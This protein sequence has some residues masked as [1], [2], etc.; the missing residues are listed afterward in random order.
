MSLPPGTW[1]IDPSRSRAE[2]EVKHLGFANARGSFTE[3][4]GTLD[5]DAG[6]AAAAQ[7]AVTVGSVSTGDPGR[8]EFLASERFFDAGRF[9]DISLSTTGT[10]QE[11]DAP[12]VLAGHLTIRDV[13]RP[14][15]LETVISAGP[16]GR[17]DAL[18]IDARCRIS[19]RDYGVK[20]TQALGASN[21]LVADLIDVRL[22]LVAEP[23]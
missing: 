16:G 15:E 10:P 18:A 5:V 19:R 20:F 14:V 4:R 11:I 23:A 9:A 21:A 6:G 13:T 7:G 12:F 17:D 1:R 8:D 22:A 3:L 2:F